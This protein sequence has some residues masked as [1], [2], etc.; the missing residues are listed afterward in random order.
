MVRELICILDVGRFS[1]GS[2]SMILMQVALAPLTGDVFFYYY[3]V[4][5]LTSKINKRRIDSL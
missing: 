3:I 2:T 5:A 4:L 1:Y